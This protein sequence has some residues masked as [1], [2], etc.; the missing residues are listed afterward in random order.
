MA[1]PLSV[2]PVPRPR[3]ASLDRREG[4]SQRPQDQA[5]LLPQ[6]IS[7]QWIQWQ[8]LKASPV[9]P[10]C[11]PPAGHTTLPALR[12]SLLGRKPSAPV[13][14]RWT[15]SRRRGPDLLRSD[16]R[17]PLLFGRPTSPGHQALKRPAATFPPN[18]SA[19][20]FPPERTERTHGTHSAPPAACVP[21]L[22]RPPGGPDRPAEHWPLAGPALPGSW[23]GGPQ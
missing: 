8:H 6:P 14:S 19:L 22:P 18:G 16:P 4:H 20:R 3:T 2:E 17:S 11:A 21:P 9:A 7:S 1:R 10:L 5:C 12:R 13:P 23:P 15:P